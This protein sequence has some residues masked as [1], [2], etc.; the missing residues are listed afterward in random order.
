MIVARATLGVGA[1]PVAAA[2]L[3]IEGVQDVGRSRPARVTIAIGA[4]R[5]RGAA[6]PP[7]SRI[8][9]APSH[10][11]SICWAS[12]S[13]RGPRPSRSSGQLAIAFALYHDVTGPLGRRVDTA[14]PD[15][16][17][18][19]PALYF[20][21]L[22]PRPRLRRRRR[23]RTPPYDLF[24]LLQ[25]NSEQAT[26]R[27]GPPARILI[28]PCPRSKPSTKKIEVVEPIG[29]RV[30]LRKDEDKKQTRVRHPPPREDRDPHPHRPRRRRS[31]PR[32]TTDDDYPI[33]R[34][35]TA[36][37]S[38]PSTPSPWTSRAT[39]ASS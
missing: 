11:S 23:R 38:T 13:H 16:I 33:R 27:R 29:A 24:V 39:T 6:V 19:S 25:L 7:R 34:N 30:L 8:T 31:P 26:E 17:L 36:C 32:W 3:A 22:Y 20:A 35:T 10:R 2:S 14:P 1:E 28:Q 12:G 37:C 5:V 18:H 15:H 9:A 4:G 21:A